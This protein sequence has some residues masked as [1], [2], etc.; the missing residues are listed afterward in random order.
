MTVGN[1]GNIDM[2]CFLSVT[3]HFEVIYLTSESLT[4]PP[5]ERGTFRVTANAPALAQAG[6]VYETTLQLQCND[7][8]SSM[9]HVVWRLEVTS[10]RLMLVLSSSHPDDA[11]SSP[12]V[13]QQTVQAG[14]SV[15]SRV[16][17][18]NLGSLTATIVVRPVQ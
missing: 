12:P 17:L 18:I 1:G 2:F 8:R 5:G 7:P 16:T 13:V 4:V 10:A 9:H 15:S 6:D 3:S 14:S 11:P